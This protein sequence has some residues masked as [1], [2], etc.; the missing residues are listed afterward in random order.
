[1]SLNSKIKPIDVL[2]QFT[3]HS[4]PFL[5]NKCSSVTRLLYMMVTKNTE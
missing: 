4:K 3:S 5:L 1:M 2:R